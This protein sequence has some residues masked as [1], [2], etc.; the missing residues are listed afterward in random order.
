[1][2]PAGALQQ[3][4][5][6]DKEV[7]RSP[8]QQHERMKMGAKVRSWRRQSGTR[9]EEFNIYSALRKNSKRVLLL[10]ESLHMIRPL[11]YVALRRR[12]GAKSWIPWLL[13]CILDVF[14]IRLSS[15]GIEKCLENDI[16]VST[17]D[18]HT[19]TS[20]EIQ[21]RYTSLLMYFMRDPLYNV[22]S[23]PILQSI[24]GSLAKIPLFGLFFEYFLEMLDYMKRYYFFKIL[25]RYQ[26]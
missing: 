13:S 17:T 22:F 5:K 19:T 8:I 1:M 26:F 7:G 24:F 10:G 15:T 23:G 25:S 6:N 12:F 16:N 2:K 21:R 14:S 9:S 20:A 4:M 11:V 3:R 18:V